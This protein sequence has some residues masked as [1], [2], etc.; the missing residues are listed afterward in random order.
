V[1][2]TDGSLTGE[3]VPAVVSEPVRVM[4]DSHSVGEVPSPVTGSVSVSA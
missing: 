2:D 1:N 3:D 4:A